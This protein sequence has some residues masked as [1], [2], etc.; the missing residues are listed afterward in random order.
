MSDYLFL[1]KTPTLNLSNDIESKYIERIAYALSS[2]ERIAIM[3]RLTNTNKSLSALS[4]ELD[5][6]ITTVTRHINALAEAGLI[7]INYQPGIKGHAKYCAHAIT[8]FTIKLSDSGEASDTRDEQSYS[9]E[10]PIG[11]F[12]HCHISAPCGLLG[13]TR[14][15]TRYDDPKQFFTPERGLAE[16]LWFNEGYISYNFPTECLYHHKCSSISFSFEV[17]SETAYYNEKWPSDLS[18]FINNVEVLTTTLPGDFGGRR[19]KYS[20]AYWS[21]NSTQYGILK[22]IKINEKGVYENDVLKRTDIK[23]DD[24]EIYTGNAVQLRLEIKKDAVHRGGINIFGKNF[25]DYNQA[26]VMT[27]K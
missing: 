27:V 26:I 13:P 17:C 25:G 21:I 23:F 5:I 22:N 24:L 3:K 2:P 11:M 1:D 20:P 9:V 16:L 7:V 14:P 12:S 8:S 15:L 4:A 19:G 6:P 10:M 18:V